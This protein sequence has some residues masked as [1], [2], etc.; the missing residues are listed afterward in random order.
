MGRL[1]RNGEEFA[2]VD[3]AVRR[4]IVSYAAALALLL[5]VAA[6]AQDIS[7]DERAPMRTRVGVG[8]QAYPS[9]P[10]SDELDIGPLFEFER[11]RGG[12]LF[13]H[14][15]GDLAIAAVEAHAT[16]SVTPDGSVTLP[17]WVR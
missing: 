12:Q 13:P 6:P 8:P 3:P 17:E 1:S 15:Y 14:L 5:P 7:G 2:L 4:D 16:V 9:Y 10:G 11:S